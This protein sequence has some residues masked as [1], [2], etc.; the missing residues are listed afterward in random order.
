MT[1]S[2]PMLRVL[3]LAAEARAEDALRAEMA[4]A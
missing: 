4:R 3:R 2:A 1:I